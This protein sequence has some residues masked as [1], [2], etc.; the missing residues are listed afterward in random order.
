MPSFPF[1]EPACRGVACDVSDCL[2]RL[3]P[4]DCAYRQRA[5]AHLSRVQ[6]VFPGAPSLTLHSG[7]VP[8]GSVPGVSPSVP[9][10]LMLCPPLIGP[11]K[12]PQW[13]DPVI[14][15]SHLHDPSDGP[16]VLVHELIHLFSCGWEILRT[17]P[18]LVL[19]AFI[20]ISGTVY[21]YNGTDPSVPAFDRSLN[22]ANEILTDFFAKLVFEDLF[23]R[24][25][26]FADRLERTA[27]GKQLLSLPPDALPL[28]GSSYFQNEPLS[29]LPHLC[30]NKASLPTQGVE[31]S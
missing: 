7:G 3:F 26:A 18:A 23:H 17:E 5:R 15:L 24:P 28:L 1:S 16:S 13:I 22:A 29:S 30:Y 6:F 10:Q 11:D 21:T 4:L 31:P 25:F 19:Q 9:S 8:I 14:Y 12:N 2:L 27:L 20:G